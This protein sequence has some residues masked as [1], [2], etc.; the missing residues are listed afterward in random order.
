MHSLPQYFNIFS[1]ISHFP[2]IKE[3]SGPIILASA[4]K[5]YS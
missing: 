3:L 2:D 5:E 4:T 1:I